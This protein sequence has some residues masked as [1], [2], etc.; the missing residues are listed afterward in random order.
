M[1]PRYEV[2]ADPETEENNLSPTGYSPCDH[3]WTPDT[4]PPYDRTQSRVCRVGSARSQ[5]GSGGT[6]GSLGPLYGSKKCL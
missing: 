2:G 6:I 3:T 1:I 5:V 4:L